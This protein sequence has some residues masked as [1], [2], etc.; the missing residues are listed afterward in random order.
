MQIHHRTTRPVA[1]LALGLI[2]S[3]S[4]VA[5]S[6]AGEE[7]GEDLSVLAE[8][9]NSAKAELEAKRAELAQLDSQIEGAGEDVTEEA[10]AEMEAQ[11]A[12]LVEEVNTLA[13]DVNAKA[14]ELINQANL[15]EGED[16][17]GVVLEAI[18][19]IQQENML[20]AREY[21]NKGG[22]YSRA[23]Q[24]LEQTSTLPV[25]NPE[26]AAALEE[27]R[28]NQYM[29]QERFAQVRNGMSPEE[30]RAILGTVNPRNRK[31]YPERNVEAWFYRKEEGIAGVYFQ[32]EGEE[33][34]VYRTEFDVATE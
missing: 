34:S 16:P 14:S 11:R 28:A 12:A 24:I 15:V 13:D 25:D 32:V 20:I 23:I 7:Q 31:E 17:E 2:L 3:V 27:A 9:L 21:I 4:L 29:D 1:L 18:L 10:L 30:V 8:P 19:T 6:G 5:C 26:L 33:S 22:D